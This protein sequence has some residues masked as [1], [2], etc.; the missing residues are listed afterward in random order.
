M[1]NQLQISEEDLATRYF[2]DHKCVDCRK[3][4]Y[5]RKIQELMNKMT[6]TK[7]A[8]NVSEDIKKISI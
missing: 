4:I 1:R 2:T 3:F 6:L 7:N 8:P 5:Q